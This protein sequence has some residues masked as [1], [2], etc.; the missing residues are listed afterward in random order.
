MRLLGLFR[1]L[2]FGWWCW[3]NGRAA[4]NPYLPTGDGAPGW[5]T[6]QVVRATL[7]WFWVAN[8][9]VSS[10]L[11]S[12]SVDGGG[13]RP[14]P[15][16]ANGRRAVDPLVG[17]SLSQSAGVTPESASGRRD[18]GNWF[19]LLLS[20]QWHDPE[21]PNVPCARCLDVFA[22]CYVGGFGGGGV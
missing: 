2:C 21:V 10:H 15:A 3:F 14:G 13:S 16:G 11:L 19:E 5:M 8:S 4:A 1:V 9:W 17:V 18:S 22:S 20:W 7:V 12:E 6:A